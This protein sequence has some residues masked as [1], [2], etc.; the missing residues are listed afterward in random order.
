MYEMEGALP[1]L[2]APSWPVTWPPRHRRTARQCRA[3][4][5][6]AGHPV[7]LTSPGVAPE[8]VPVSDG[9]SI[10]TASA[11]DAQ[12][13]T[14]KSLRISSLSTF[15]PQN[16]AGYS[17]R[18]A[19]IHWLFTSFPHLTCGIQENTPADVAICNGHIPDRQ[20]ACPACNRLTTSSASL[21]C[22]PILSM[23]LKTC[24]TVPWRSMT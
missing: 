6:V 16:T 9:E 20:A 11:S 1:G 4:V 24:R 14:A 21:T 13:F 17:Q 22:W 23:E 8:V 18:A 2:A 10:S 3:P 15:C 19:V 7:S 5:R 12:G